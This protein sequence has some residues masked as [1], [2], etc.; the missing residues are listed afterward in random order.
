MLNNKSIRK[1][2]TRL[3]LFGGC[4][5]VET[6]IIV[7]IIISFTINPTHLG[8][9]IVLSMCVIGVLASYKFILMTLN[10]IDETYENILKKVIWEARHVKQ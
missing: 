3:C 1:M 10:E 8:R 4:M 5:G 7:H 9:W 6:Y 2:A